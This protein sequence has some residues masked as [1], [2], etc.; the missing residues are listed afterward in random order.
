MKNLAQYTIALEAAQHEM[1]LYKAGMVVAKAYEK[2]YTRMDM[3]GDEVSLFNYNKFFV[4]GRLNLTTSNVTHFQHMTMRLEDKNLNKLK[5]ALYTLS[6]SE[7]G[8]FFAL[9]ARAD[10]NED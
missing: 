3:Q 1:K 10:L 8:D 4:C 6:K 2:N 7:Q 5:R 9:E